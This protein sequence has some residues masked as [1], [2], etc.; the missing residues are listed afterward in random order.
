MDVM[1]VEDE[2]PLVRNLRE[3][4]PLR[5]GKRYAEDKR[6]PLR[7]GKRSPSR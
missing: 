5:W 4:S 7:W 6:A 1:M 3:A 2:G